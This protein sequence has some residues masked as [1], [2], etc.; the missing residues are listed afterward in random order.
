MSTI[1]LRCLT[2]STKSSLVIHSHLLLFLFFSP[3]SKS[4]HVLG[5]INALIGGYGITGLSS[6]RYNRRQPSICSRP[7][8]ISSGYILPA[9]LRY[10]WNNRKITG[11]AYVRPFP[12]PVLAS[13]LTY[14]LAN[15]N[16]RN[17]CSASYVSSD[18]H[19]VIFSHTMYNRCHGSKY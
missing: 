9:F 11:S 14:T 17:S 18:M 3:I 1:S 13:E 5:I 7:F 4:D 15:I 16:L 8:P 12:L 19:N 10:D 2:S 6:R